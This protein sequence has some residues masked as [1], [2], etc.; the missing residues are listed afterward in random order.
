MLGPHRG[1]DSLGTVAIIDIVSC[2]I[3]AL[4]LLP[5]IL[6]LLERRREAQGQQVKAA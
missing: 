1:L 6:L 2:F 3:T 4:G 5:A